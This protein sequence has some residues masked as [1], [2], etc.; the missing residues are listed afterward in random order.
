MQL[1][2]LSISLD[3]DQEGDDLM[4]TEAIDA[5]AVMIIPLAQF[6]ESWVQSIHEEGNA[7]EPDYESYYYYQQRNRREFFN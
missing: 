4:T 7:S 5:G 6:G 3:V 1:I 2:Y